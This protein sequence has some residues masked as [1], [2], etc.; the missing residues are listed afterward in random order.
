MSLSRRAFVLSAAAAIGGGMVVGIR[1][2]PRGLHDAREAVEI[3]DWITVAPDNTVTI[4]IAQ[5]EMGQGAMTS[6]A[7]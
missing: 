3:R 5:M 1:F 7:Q 2:L 6:M 4:R